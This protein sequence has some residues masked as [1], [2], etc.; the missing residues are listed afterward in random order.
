MELATV[1]IKLSGAPQ[2]TVV[3][4]DVTPAQMALYAFMHGED[5]AEGVQITGVDKERTI[6]Q[7]MDRLRGIF[8]SEEASKCLNKLFPGI[9]PQLPVTFSS[10]GFSNI[11]MVKND[12][13]NQP[14]QPDNAAA[15]AIRQRI[16]DENSR[17]DAEAAANQTA[18]VSPGD[19]QAAQ[20]GQLDDTGGALDFTDQ[21]D[22]TPP[23]A[24]QHQGQ[25]QG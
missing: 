24:P 18:P 11:T 13:A 4:R 3:K 2:N 1:E 5:C 19:L 17:R 25:G 21:P 23:P 9:A 8:A 22:F 16:E 15:A 7:E 12:L 14:P 6:A 20:A 10:I